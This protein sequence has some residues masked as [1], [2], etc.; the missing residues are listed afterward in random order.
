MM[1]TAAIPFSVWRKIAMATW[2]PRRDPMI[3]ASLEVDATNL[4][5]YLDEVRTATGE[6]VTPVHLVGRAVAKIFEELP[7]LNGRVVFG[8][9]VPS[10]TID[11]FYVVSLRTDVVEGA[12][13]SRTDLS[14][15]VVRRADEKPPWVQA[16][17]LAEKADRIRTGRDPMFRQTKVLAMRLPALVLRPV[18]DTI[19]F[20]TEDLQ[21]PVP[22]L[23]LEARPFGSFL[24]TNVG[25]YGLDSSYAA[26]ATSCHAPGGVMVGAI[27]EKPV[28]I[29]HEVVA[30]PVLP[31]SAMID[32]RYIDG[33]QGAVIA[34]VVRDYLEDPW[35][36]DPIPAP[37]PA[38]GLAEV[39]SGV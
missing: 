30:R 19:A 39:L 22:L 11:V 29:D 28:V 20:I 14:G 4:L 2:Q 15:A 31:L 16:H 32:H 8:E 5:R 35:R 18:L 13:A 6:H 36:F 9:F 21:L 17:E 24:V 37:V 10:P 23:G 3:F 33:Y 25:T 38:E 27:R 1:A 7:G 34:R 26:I 12:E